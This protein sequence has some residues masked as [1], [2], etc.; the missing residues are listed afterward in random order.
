MNKSLHFAGRTGLIWLILCAFALRLYRLDTQSLRGDEAISAVY[1]NLPLIETIDISSS[2][3]PHPPLFYILLHYWE[4]L[5]GTKEFSIRFLAL[6][7][8]V[9]S[10]PA[11]FTLLKPCAGPQVGLIAAALLTLNTFHI[12]NAQDARNYTWLI[13][14]SLLSSLFLWQYLYL[15]RRRGVVWLYYTITVIA[16]FYMHYY[17][18][19]I[20]A[21]HG[22]YLCFGH[23]GHLRRWLGSVTL[24]LIILIPWLRIS[25]PYILE[26]RGNFAAA[27]PL[28]IMRLGLQA[29]SGG[30]AEL[31]EFQA[32]MFAAVALAI[33]GFYRQWRD[34]KMNSLFLWLYLALPFLGIMALTLRGQAFTERYLLA[35]LP[36]YLAF[37]ALGI[38]WLWRR[39]VWWG[40]WLLGIALGSLLWL[41]GS[42]WWRYHFDERIAK[43]PEWREAFEL[44]YERQ[45]PAT[46]ALIYN[47]PEASITYYL[48]TYLQH[49][50][51]NPERLVA[52]FVPYQAK[53]NWDKIDAELNTIAQR[54]EQ[55][56]FIQPEDSSWYDDGL[57]NQWLTRYADRVI[58]ADFRWVRVDLYQTSQKFHQAMQVQL[59]T[60][61]NGIQLYGFQIFPD[62]NNLNDGILYL[63]PNEPFKLSLYWAS[64]GPAEIPLTVFT[65]LIDPTGFLRGGQDNQ[66]VWNTYPTTD[67][68][69]DELIVDKYRLRLQ[70]GA[71]PGDYQLWVGLYDPA[72]GERMMIIDQEKQGLSDHIVLD[73]PIIMSD[74]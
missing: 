67:W 44:V 2:T 38:R 4:N 29:F 33:L 39:Q 64:K 9:L 28:T 7:P 27:A 26:Y 40:N 25:W 50:T 8:A 62:S 5:A 3:E 31:N 12:W 74:K 32:S 47:I 43:A 13:F 11:L 58:E 14:L 42:M 66:P 15:P 36:P 6:I 30:L 19:F 69:R 48:D 63:K 61:E 35:A 52:Y 41:N 57:V 70:A 16:L 68:Q 49:G 10:V 1:A 22:V 60:F 71:M 34:N 59:A 37:I 73:V 51:Q 21:F 20:V 53:L 46:E 18:L 65:Q 45:D 24:T 56:W 54:H 23:F 17:A 72:T 55:L